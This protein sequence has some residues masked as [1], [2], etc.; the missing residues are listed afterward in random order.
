MADPY[1]HLLRTFAAIA[2]GTRVLDLGCGDGVRAEA[3]ARLGFAVDAVDDDPAR[4]ARERVGAADAHAAVIHAPDLAAVPFDDARYDWAVLG[5][6]IAHLGSREAVVAVLAEARRLLTPGGWLYVIVPGVPEAT[7]PHA[8]AAAYA[9]DSA[10]VF[11]FTPETLTDLAA[12]AGLVVAERA[13]RGE[14]ERVHAIF[15]RVESGTVG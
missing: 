2:P 11:T 9:A 14:G 15:R 7:N 5:E 6:E 4:G 1:D 3:L 8:P 10:P 12:E 13:R